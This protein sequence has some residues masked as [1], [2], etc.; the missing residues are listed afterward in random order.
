MKALRFPGTRSADEG[1]GRGGAS[2]LGARDI[3]GGGGGRR[4]LLGWGIAMKALRFPGTRSADE[5][6]GRGG[7]SG[8]GA[9]FADTMPDTL[10]LLL[11]VEAEVFLW[12]V[13][14]TPRTEDAIGLDNTR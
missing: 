3:L 8:L 2:G 4:K 6:V 10:H 7:A 11:L 5:G 14:S 1:V 9:R 13:L 12:K